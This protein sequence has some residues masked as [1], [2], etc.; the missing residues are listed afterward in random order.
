MLFPKASY[1]N[2]IRDLFVLTK[3]QLMIGK[4]FK[5]PRQTFQLSLHLMADIDITVK[6]KPSSE[7]QLP[8]IF[9]AITNF[10]MKLFFSVIQYV[11]KP[12]INQYTKRNPKTYKNDKQLINKAHHFYYFIIYLF[13]ILLHNTY[14]A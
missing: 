5:V 9:Y 13:K 14:H 1:H 2:Q 3:A 7:K 8:N 6:F 4:S 10:F 12:T 11:S